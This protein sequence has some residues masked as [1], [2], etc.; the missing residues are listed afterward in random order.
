MASNWPP[1]ARD[2]TLIRSYVVV[3]PLAV[4]SLTEAPELSMSINSG[5]DTE[6]HARQAARHP[7][8]EPKPQ[9]RSQPCYHKRTA[10][11]YTPRQQDR[12]RTRRPTRDR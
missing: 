1:K 12:G 5:M 6:C 7:S 8:R 2:I 9:G 10:P 4:F 11:T 3:C